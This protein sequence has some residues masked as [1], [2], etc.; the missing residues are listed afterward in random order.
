M[1]AVTATL[2]RYWGVST[3]RP[4][5]RE[6]VAASLEVHDQPCLDCNMRSLP[7]SLDFSGKNV[8]FA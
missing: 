7:T 8:E 5:Q 3:F 6:A 4:L 2:H 1:D